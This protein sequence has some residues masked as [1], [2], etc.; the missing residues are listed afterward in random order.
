SAMRLIAAINTALDVHLNVRTLF[1]APTITQLTP[2]L[3]PEVG[4]LAPLVAGE[5][6]SVIPLSFGQGRLWFLEQ[7]QG[8]SP[9]YNMP[10][11]LRLRGRLD[12]GALWAALSDVVGRHE[13]LRTIYPDVDG[14]PR[15]QIVTAEQTNFGWEVVDA[16]AW[17]QHQLA[18]AIDVTATHTFHL[19]TETPLQA[20][21]FNLADD[22]HVLAAV[23][24]HIA[25]DGFSLSPLVADLGRAYSSRCARQAP[26]W[27]A[28][29]V[30]YADYAL[31]QRARFGDL[32]DRESPIGVQLAYWEQALAGMPERLVLPSDRPYPQVAGYG[33]AS[34]AVEWPAELQQRIRTVAREHN[35]T[36]FM[37]IQ[38]GLAVLLS[39]MS[40]S[41]DIAVGFAVAG[42][43]DPALEQLVGFFVNT[44]VMRVQLDGEATVG[45]LLGQVRVRSLEGLEHQDV[46]FELL[47]ERLNPIRSMSH[48]PLVQVGLTWQGHDGPVAG[49]DLGDLQITPMP[50]QAH[51]ARMDLTFSLGERWT[52][53]AQPAGIGGAVEFRTD[54]FDAESVVALV[55]RLQRVLVAMVADPLARVS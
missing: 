34:V 19:A 52:A 29:P 42:R 24:H 47:V 31:W 46:P 44:L 4:G 35:A 32:D 14:A 3:H 15:Q 41:P 20:K 27:A 11:A 22:D 13:T 23:V 18:D 54:L 36:S 49:L 7:L 51:T 10:V 8:P 39:K 6:P 53:D 16:T 30:Q 40:A 26:D 2:H 9:V 25:A 17:S 48:H 37:V 55:D 28:L 45:D 38:A 5:R 21:L 12:V 43:N 1:D 33:G 50:L